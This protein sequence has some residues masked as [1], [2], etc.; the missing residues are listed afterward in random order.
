MNW[1]LEE[2]MRRVSEPLAACWGAL[3]WTQ[4]LVTVAVPAVSGQASWTRAPA[5]APVIDA[6]RVPVEA[7]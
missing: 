3:S 4:S 1:Q 5:F 2:S 6:V 7:S